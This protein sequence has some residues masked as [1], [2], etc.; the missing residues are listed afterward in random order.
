VDVQGKTFFAKASRAP[1]M[2][3]LDFESMLQLSAN[4]PQLS[5]E[6]ICSQRS[7]LAH[8]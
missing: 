6:I 7:L 3:A 4:D 2:Y 1:I 5:E 8:I